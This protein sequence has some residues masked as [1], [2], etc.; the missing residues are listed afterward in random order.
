MN[1]NHEIKTERLLLRPFNICDAEEI[2]VWT[3]DERVTRYM[4]YHTYG[5]AGEVR[6]WLSSIEQDTASCHWG[7][8]RISDGRLVGSGCLEKIG[9]E[10]A[11]SWAIS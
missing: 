10:D 3:G 7:Y 8:E 1:G 4:V 2:F 9:R 5:S 6:N 11:G